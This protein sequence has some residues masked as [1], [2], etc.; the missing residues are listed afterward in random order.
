[1]SLVVSW[2]HHHCHSTGLTLSQP[3]LSLFGD[4][5]Y[6]AC[7]IGPVLTSQSGLFI[8]EKEVLHKVFTNC[9]MVLWQWLATNEI[10]ADSVCTWHIRDRHE[11]DMVI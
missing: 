3:V 10:M 11:F 1:M 7:I 6:D 5:M 2:W 4:M 9:Y 8:N